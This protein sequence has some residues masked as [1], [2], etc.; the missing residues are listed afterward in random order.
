[1]RGMRGRVEIGFEERVEVEIE[2]GAVEL[3]ED[4]G[5]VRSNIGW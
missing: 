5:E 3:M 4:I 1:M 2:I